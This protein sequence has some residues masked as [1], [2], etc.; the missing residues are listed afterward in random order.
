MMGRTSLVF[1]LIVAALLSGIAAQRTAC[2]TGDIVFLLDRSS[3]INRNEHNI[4]KNFTTTLVDSFEVGEKLVRIGLCQ[5]SDDPK[6]EFYLNKYYNK[7]DLNTQILK[8]DYTGGNTYLGRALDHIKEYFAESRGSRYQVPKNLVLITDGDSHDDVEDA[9]DVLRDLNIKVF[10]IGVGDVHDLQLLQI[11]G[12][13]E[14]MFTV[15]N[16][17]VLHSIKQGVVDVMCGDEQKDDPDPQPPTPPPTPPPPPPPPKDCTIDIAIGFDIS[18]RT[19]APGELLVRSHTKLQ[20]F[21]P[22]ILDYVSSFKDLCCVGPTPVKPNIAFQVVDRDGRTLYDTNFEGYSADVV[23]KVMTLPMSEPSYFNTAMLNSFKER[24]K[25]K[26][27]AHV[28]VLVIFSDGLDEDVMKLEHESELLRKSGVSAL[29]TV[30]LEGVRDPAQLQMVEFGRGFGYKPPLS[31]GM[32]SVASVIYKQIDAISDKECCNVMCKCSGHEG[33]PGLPGFPGSKGSP[34]QTGQPGFP[35]DEGA[36]GERGP[37]GPVGRQGIEGCP[38]TRGQ[39]GYRGVSGNR[40]ENGEDGL[41][42]IDGEQGLT[43]TNGAKGPRGDPG[44]PGIPGIRGEAGPKGERGL[45]GD[46]G[47]P[48]SDNTDR[49]PKGERG[50]PGLPGSPGRDG[51]PGDKG[52][53]GN[54]GPDGRRG[55]GGG[56]GEPGRPGE[57][58]LPGSPG[59]AGPQGRRGGNG[60]PGPKGISGFPGPQG[61]PGPAGDP[62]QPGRRGANGPK[63]QPGDPGVKGST[64]PVG[65]IGPPGQDGQDGYGTKGSKGVKGDPGFPGYSGLVGK[66]GVKGTKGYPGRKGNYGR[67]GNSGRPGEPGVPGEP[68]YDGHRGAKGPP[69]TPAMSECQMIGYIKDN[70]ACCQGESR[71]PA[72]PTELVFGLDMS[73][74]VTPAAFERQRSALLSLLDDITI[75]ESNCP[76]GARVAVVAYNAYTKYVIRFQDY[77]RKTQLIEA[78]KNIALERTSI[79]RNLGSAMRF[80]GQNVFKRVRKGLM[81]RKVAVFFSSGPSEDNSDIVT[82][83]ME[84]RALKIVPAVISLRAAPEVERAI[85]VDDTGNTLFIVLGRDTA[86]DLQKV[87]NCAI[88]YDP[89]RRS[90][91]CPLIQDVLTPQEVNVD[92]VLVLDGSREMQ[93]DEY[94]GG[95]QLLGSVVE[96]LAVSPQPRRADGQARVAV[97][98]SGTKDPKLEFD[99]GTFQS[100]TLMRRHLMGNMTQRGGSS[101]LGKTLDFTLKEVLM[102]AGQPRRR[103]AVLAVVGTKTASWD[104]ARL[105]W[106]SSRAYCDGVALFV[107][108]VGKR[109]DREQ[110]EELA[111]W[112]V[113]QHLIHLDR[114]RADE[115]SYAQHF[116][117]VFLS[118]LSK[119]INAYPRPSFKEDCNKLK[120]PDDAPALKHDDSLIF[121]RDNGQGSAMLADEFVEEV[122]EKFWVQTTQLD[123]IASV[124]PGDGQSFLSGENLSGADTLMKPEPTSYVSKDVDTPD[125]AG[126]DQPDTCLLRPNAGGCQNY[127]IS[128]FFDSDQGRCSRFWYG[129]CGGN[130]NRFNTLTECQSL[131]V[132]KS[133]LVGRRGGRGRRGGA[134]VRQHRPDRMKKSVALH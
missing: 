100:S 123:V 87:K 92:L 86:A 43:G 8:V 76:S 18:R 54:P 122:E 25:I 37:P 115:Q 24:F 129:G 21:L 95:Q 124:T 15:R 57:P 79:R 20:N 96:H 64:G 67:G 16:Y 62:G 68:G 94:A 126:A 74:D 1:S 73:Q 60:E 31:I 131:C 83:I 47:E 114:L 109:Y 53:A 13:P 77:Q 59:A 110:V 120:E 19:G 35:G 22:Q 6:D 4:M 49:G 10:A 75:S 99:L 30:A 3:S 88:C 121:D 125:E 52:D 58:G 89:C 56:K 34:G 130:G 82:A 45:R 116:F 90:E 33:I 32:Q 26:S 28:K 119:G 70:C 118:A 29:L 51:E 7:D 44:N 71:C 41:D 106:I 27:K 65:P 101:A 78:V 23:N 84:Y 98:Q 11:A 36:P 9:A 39:K 2:K 14:R 55:S 93:A 111:G 112:P 50:Y 127:T 91:L 133:Q 134:G 113:A 38:G 48:G 80:V 128:W 5:F 69:G 40:G 104:Q 66:D 117:R 102:K 63:G 42:G 132:T 97:I 72:Y 12:T 85:K 17:D 103:R 107:V 105:D 108:T 46:P 81:M 61:G